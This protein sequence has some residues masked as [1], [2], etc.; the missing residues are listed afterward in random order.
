M[1][2]YDN[3]TD[4]CHPALDAGSSTGS[5]VIPYRAREPGMTIAL[6]ALLLLLGAKSDPQKKAPRVI[7]LEE[8]EIWGSVEKPN[9]SFLIPRSRLN[10]LNPKAILSKKNLI[11]KIE[12]SIQSDIFD[13]R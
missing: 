10:F 11:K 13:V 2:A 4:S 12:E 5:R 6:L 7:S 1:K 9:V 8:I 3:K